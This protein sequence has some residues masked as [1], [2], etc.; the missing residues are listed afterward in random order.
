MSLFSRVSLTSAL[1][2][3]AVVGG[4]V[5]STGGAMFSPGDLHAGRTSTASD[6]VRG[7]RTLGGIRSHAELS[8]D[9]D[10]CHVPPGSGDRMERRCLACHTEIA[11]EMRE[12]MRDSSARATG[13]VHGTLRDASSC[14]NCHTEHRGANGTLTRVDGSASAH[15]QLGFPLDGAHAKASCA[16]CHQRTPGDN[17]FSKAPTTCV[18]CHERDDKH[19]GGFGADCASC[20]STT[21]WR[22]ARFS[23]DVFP[24]DHGGEGQIACAT[25]HTDGTNYKQ[26]T[27]MGCHE[28]SPARIEAEHR[29]EVNTSNLADC[30]RCHRG[31]RGEGGEH[32]GREHEGRRRRR[33]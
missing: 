26:Y 24:L 2:T 13:F 16:S 4:L 15:E 29:G 32:E 5:I 8:H 21:T 12:G 25:C 10:R 19:D 17:R 6:S 3:V 1:V 31:G 9:C 27:C 14:L 30:L 22:G 33:D 28:H 18:G 7:D 23:H 20:H 11:S